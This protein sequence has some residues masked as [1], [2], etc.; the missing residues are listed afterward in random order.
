MGDGCPSRRTHHHQGGWRRRLCGTHQLACLSVSD[1]PEG[2]DVDAAAAAFDGAVRA[3]AA[4]RPLPAALTDDDVAPW[5]ST[6]QEFV[7]AQ[8]ALV[9]AGEWVHGPSDLMHILGVQFDELRHSRV[10]GWLLDPSARHGLGDRILARILEAGWP[11]DPQPPTGLAVVS[12]EVALHRTRADVVVRMGPTVLVIE[13]KVLAPERPRQ[14]EDLYREWHTYGA[15]SDLRFLLLSLDGHAPHTTTSS[16]AA[17]AWRSM[18]YA[19]LWA[20]LD[21]VPLNADTL[22]LEHDSL[23]QYA[24]TLAAL[25]RFDRR[26]HMFHLNTGGGRME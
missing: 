22:R 16:E 1:A 10:V 3:W 2:F 25:R 21:E 14:C 8:A 5:A 13:N 12:F 18:S 6:Y 4:I 24:A 15:A 19:A 7:D 23:R 26:Q 9:R 17:E 20:L 11:S